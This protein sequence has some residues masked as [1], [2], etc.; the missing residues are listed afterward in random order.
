MIK[1]DEFDEFVVVLMVVLLSYGGLNQLGWW[2][3]FVWMVAE[4]VNG[5]Q[6]F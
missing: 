6:I 3:E 2:P 5:G 1:F 4:V